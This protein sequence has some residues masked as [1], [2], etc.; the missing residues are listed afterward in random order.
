MKSLH[1]FCKKDH[2]KLKSIN[3][4]FATDFQQLDFVAT[5][6][7]IK[8]K[9]KWKL[10]NDSCFKN[11]SQKINICKDMAWNSI[12]AFKLNLFV[13]VHWMIDISAKLY[14]ESS[15][16][17]W[18]VCIV[19]SSKINT[20]HTSMSRVCYKEHQKI[21]SSQLHAFDITRRLK[22]A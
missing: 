8:S 14:R 3:Y 22:I 9:E 7:Q 5:S 11:Y 18:Y 2:N 1:I 12:R 4:L 13:E 16:N 15:L 19:S 17:D 21:K 10:C 6:L 20:W